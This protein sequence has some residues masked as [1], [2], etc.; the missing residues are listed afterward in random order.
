MRI[1][2]EQKKAINIYLEASNSE[3][4]KRHDSLGYVWTCRHLTVLK[5]K[6]ERE[7]RGHVQK[8]QKD[9]DSRSGDISPIPSMYLCDEIAILEAKILG[10]NNLLLKYNSTQIQLGRVLAK[11][12]NLAAEKT[13]TIGAWI[14][15]LCSEK[16]T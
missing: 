11:T 10:I 15:T 13:C 7:M 6:L 9:N 3:A 2:D 8:R 14:Y 4:L 16:L 12:P 5:T 1:S